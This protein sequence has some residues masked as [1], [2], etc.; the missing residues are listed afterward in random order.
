MAFNKPNVNN[1]WAATGEVISPATAKIA[2][3]WI[4][5]IPDYE[6]ENW[7][8]QRQDQFNAHINQYGIPVWDSVT[9]YIAGKSYVQ[10]SDGEIYKAITT[11]TNKNPTVSSADWQRAFDT[12]DSSYSKT[13]ADGRFAKQASNLSDL[14]NIATARNNLSVY[15]KT[16]SD[17]R[18]LN[19]SSNLSDLAN[20][21]TAR[22]NLSVYS[23]AEA[24]AAYVRKANNLSDLTSAATARTNLNVYAKTDLYTRTESDA[25]YVNSAGDTM[26]GKLT[27]DGDPTSAL[28]AVT[29]QYVDVSLAPIGSVVAMATSTLPSGYLKCNGAAISRSTYSDLFATIG[30]TFGAGNGSTTFNL[31]DLRGEFIRGWDDSRG[32]DSGRNFGSQQFDELKSHN[33]TGLALSAGS[34]NHLGGIPYPTSYDPARYPYGQGGTTRLGFSAGNFT[35]SAKSTFTSTEGAHTHTL[36]INS[37]GGTETRPR[38]V[39]LM[40][41]I[42]F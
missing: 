26:T 30:T 13:E 27:L 4:A 15:S 19:E 25:R 2:Q 1:I 7:I 14:T 10:G 38:N 18:Y 24:D 37:T 22:T 6:F 29:K 20:I 12:F 5:E 40:Y 17:S 28:H 42:K 36:S 3:G 8:Q 31:P 39:A 34:H 23:K 32:I 16:E 33:H 35:N 41:V 11:N 9:E 21:A